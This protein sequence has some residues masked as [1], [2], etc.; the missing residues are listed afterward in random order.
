MPRLESLDAEKE[1]LPEIRQATLPAQ[2]KYC[3]RRYISV[4]ACEENAVDGE[5]AMFVWEEIAYL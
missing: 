1:N 4:V 5:K 2:R 3:I